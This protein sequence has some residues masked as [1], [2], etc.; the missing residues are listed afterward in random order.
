VRRDWRRAALWVRPLARHLADREQRALRRLEGLPGLPR[1][2]G[3]GP[4]RRYRSWLPGRPLQEAA[5]RDPAWYGSALRLLAALHR[6]GV[7]HN[8]LA[9]E[10][11]WLVLEDGS[12]ALVDFQMA[13]VF[14]RRGWRFR[15]QAREDLRHLL[16]HKR[17][18][19]PERLTPR[20]RRLLAA[21]SLPA[22]LWRRTGKRLYLLVTRRWLGWA[23]RE[24]AGDRGRPAA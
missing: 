6:R 4:G 21:P 23:D 17:S 15:L 5:P 13:S 14:R 24:G 8:D 16:K 1:S 20:D 19:W 11:N 12:A 9:K 18:Y 2:R 10:P 3:G 22:R 7:T